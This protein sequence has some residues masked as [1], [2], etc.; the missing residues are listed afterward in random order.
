MRAGDEL[1]SVVVAELTDMVR[2]EQA[3]HAARIRLPAVDV[4][5]IAPAEVAERP[6][7]GNLGLTPRERYLLDER[8]ERRKP[9]MNRENAVPDQRRDG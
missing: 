3:A 8:D 5:G 9:A 1:E 4:I 2:A 7:G 6:A